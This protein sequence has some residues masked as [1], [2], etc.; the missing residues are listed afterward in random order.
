MEIAHELSYETLTR[1]YFE[2]YEYYNSVGEEVEHP[3][4]GFELQGSK[5]V[6]MGSYGIKGLLPYGF[7]KEEMCYTMSCGGLEAKMMVWTPL[8]AVAAVVA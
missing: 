4:P 5:M 2:S 8:K 7:E 6:E 3:E 1:V